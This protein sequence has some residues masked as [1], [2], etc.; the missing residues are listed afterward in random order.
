MSEV[1]VWIGWIPTIL[2]ERLSADIGDMEERRRR[3]GYIVTPRKIPY[4]EQVIKECKERLF[5]F[6]FV[7][8]ELCLSPLENGT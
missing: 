5:I 7:N 3:I 6:Y 2:C 4:S 1:T 8:P